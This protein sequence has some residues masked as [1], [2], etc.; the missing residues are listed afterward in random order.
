MIALGVWATKS[1]TLA[2]VVVAGCSRLGAMRKSRTMATRSLFPNFRSCL[3]DARISGPPA[4]IESAP[5]HHAF[6]IT[7]GANLRSRLEPCAIQKLDAIQETRVQE[8]RIQETARF[9]KPGFRKPRDSGNCAIQETVFPRFRKPRF[10]KP[11]DS[12]N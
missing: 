9:R 1:M 8:T 4:N 10:R 2:V 3:G 7:E 5:K 12:G 6:D 11:Q